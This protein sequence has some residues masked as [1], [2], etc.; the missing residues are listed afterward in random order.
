MDVGSIPGGEK[1]AV[2]GSAPRVLAR[3]A[4]A[5]IAIKEATLRRRIGAGHD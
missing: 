3:R 5:I 4:I 2:N 1:R